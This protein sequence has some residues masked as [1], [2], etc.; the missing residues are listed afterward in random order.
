MDEALSMTPNVGGNRRAALPLANDKPC[1]GA[2][3]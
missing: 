3:G 1:A 2:S